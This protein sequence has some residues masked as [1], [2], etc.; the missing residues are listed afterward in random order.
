MHENF[1]SIFLMK[2][3]SRLVT[4]R[5]IVAGAVSFLSL[6]VIANAAPD[7][8]PFAA[9]S[10]FEHAVF[11]DD[12][13]ILSNDIFFGGAHAIFGLSPASRT[14]L[15]SEM[16]QSKTARQTN[17]VIEAEGSSKDDFSLTSWLAS[18]FAFGRGS[19]AAPV[20]PNAPALVVD[21]HW[22]AN[23]AAPIA[24]GNGLTA[25]WNTSGTNPV[26][27]T[28]P[29]GAVAPTSWVDGSNAF[30]GGVAGTVVINGV[31]DPAT[32]FVRTTGYTFETAS[33]NDTINGPIQLS[34][35]VNLFLHDP[36]N[37][38]NRTLE[39]G[40]SITGGTG[41]GITI[42]GNP[43]V[44]THSR[45]LLTAPTSSIDVP[46]TILRGGTGVGPIGVVAGATGQVITGSITNNTSG[47]T[48]LGANTG[49]TLT[50][51]GVID[52]TA[53]LRVS[54]TAGSESGLDGGGGIV[55]LTANNTFAGDTVV[56]TASGGLL[57]LAAT[58]GQALGETANVVINSGTLRL[59][60]PNQINNAAGVTL[61]GGTF[62]L[63]GFS[64]G[65]PGT[66][67]VGALTLMANSTI[68]FAM[69]ATSSIIQFAGLTAHT[70]TTGP[71][72]SITNWNGNAD[73]GGGPER[74]LFSG[75][76][77]DFTT[78]YA[79]SDVSFN[80]LTGYNAFQF[81]G[82]YEITAVPEP[83]TWIGAALALAA[84]GFTQRR[85]F[86]KTLKS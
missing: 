79:Q 48:L 70:P 39:I 26:W 45:I 46:I 60:Q 4:L 58:S 32:V 40:G 77:A 61:G 62:A 6:T 11:G 50:V 8:A 69:G 3:N 64:E 20:A 49:A 47:P 52:G 5:K 63:N 13:G 53:G 37:N 28:D 73:M 30:F 67:G 44:G 7:K 66:N 51:S 84:I 71:N 24:G 22:D 56:Q 41:S 75:S 23:G 9:A 15:L 42:Q 31:V 33:F 85:R 14:L 18:P 78:Q 35:G 19:A 34:D 68:D 10:P 76:V 25:T 74:L 17:A 12:W 57:V 21:L 82:F 86:G 43:F 81:E 83:G 2:H 59:D 38:S 36:L 55:V 80:G 54:N 65:A 72:L 27:N 29:A 16:P 1:P